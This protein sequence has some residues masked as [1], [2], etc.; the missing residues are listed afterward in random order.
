MLGDARAVEVHLEAA[1]GGTEVEGLA[2]FGDV[3]VHRVGEL[4]LTIDQGGLCLGRQ[5]CQ[6][7]GLDGR[8]DLGGLSAL[9]PQQG[10]EGERGEREE[11]TSIHGGSP[12]ERSNRRPTW[13]SGYATVR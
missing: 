3:E 7:G 1:V 8:P 2:F 10:D 11:G 6:P 5:V 9:T 12:F 13:G 4:G